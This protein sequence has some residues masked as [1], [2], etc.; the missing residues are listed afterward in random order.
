MSISMNYH[1]YF[2]CKHMYVVDILLCTLNDKHIF[3]YFSVLYII[4]TH[5]I[6]A[7]SIHDYINYVL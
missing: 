5:S 4:C 3:I 6:Q 7:D 2:Y 1:A